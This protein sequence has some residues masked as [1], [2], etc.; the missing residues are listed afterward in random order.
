MMFKRFGQR[1][2]RYIARHEGRLSLPLYKISRYYVRMY[3]NLDYD[4]QT[5]GEIFILQRLS[6][7]DISTVFDVGANRGEWLSVASQILTDAEIHAFEIAPPTFDILAKSYSGNISFH[8][9]DF[10]LSNKEGKCMIDY[11]PD[12]DGVSTLVLDKK[13]HGVNSER[14][15]VRTRRGD[16]Y[17]RDKNISRIDFLK[18]DVEGAEPYVLQG[19]AEMIKNKSIDI[20]QFEYGMANI[21][22]KYLLKDFYEF[23]SRYGYVVGKLFPTG[24][25]FKVYYPED[26]DFLGPNYI[27]ASGNRKDIIDAIGSKNKAYEV[28][29]GQ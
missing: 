15:E 29:S 12:A 24:V 26:E 22:T 4:I 28:W 1:S 10:G 9:N 16:D 2:L 14:M 27:A 11:F 18:I 17:C 8:L 3:K 5:N 19:F 23:F 21:Y 25:H 7:F 13:I 6:D 20:I